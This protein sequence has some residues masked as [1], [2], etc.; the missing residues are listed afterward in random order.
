MK[1]LVF[2]ALF[3]V[4]TP[5]FA[6]Q[7]PMADE[8]APVEISAKHSL[9]WNRK[10][11][12]YTARENAIAKQGNFQVASDLLTA[13]YTDEKGAT[14]IS[15]LVAAGNVVITSPPYTVHGDQATYSV[16]D[17]SVLLTGRDLRIETVTERLTARDKIEF[18]G[19]E[20]RLTAVGDAVA[21]RGTD[22]LRANVM[23]AFFHQGPEGKLVLQKITVDGNVSIKTLKETVNGSKGVYDVVAG[24]AILTGDIKILQGENWLQGTRAVV[25]LKTGISQLFAE[26]GEGRVKGLFYPKKKPQ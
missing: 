24:K 25:D 9:E 17:N 2:L 10:A 11:K 18:Y 15:T 20:N 22:T 13:H 19:R 3:L 12:T 4:T 23:N 16:P 6:Q 7:M 5:A 21:V 26:G 8:N 1:R 14:D